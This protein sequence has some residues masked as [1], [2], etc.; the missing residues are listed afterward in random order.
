[1]G[2]NFIF[3]RLLRVV[4]CV[5]AFGRSTPM[6][7]L[8]GITLLF[9]HSSFEN[10]LSFATVD[11]ISVSIIVQVTWCSFARVYIPNTWNLSWKS[12]ILVIFILISSFVPVVVVYGLVAKSCPTLCHPMDCS[13][14][15]SSVHGIFQAR[16]LEWIAIS[17][18]RRS[19]QP[20]NRTQVSCIAG[21]FFTYW[22][23]R[24]ISS[25]YHLS[26]HFLSCIFSWLSPYCFVLK[27]FDYS[28]PFIFLNNFW[29]HLNKY[30]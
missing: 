11:S 7:L 4:I 27:Y 25:P 26:F 6:S 9:T 24:E 16:I 8:W 22:A 19:S 29:I 23:I 28:W 30:Y 14:P 3:Y 20:R 21:R 13:P 12:M 5:A 2:M 18:S 17:F 15:A 10:Y 1:M